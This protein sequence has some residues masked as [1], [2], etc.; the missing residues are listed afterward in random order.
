MVLKESAILMIPNPLFQ[1]CQHH[2]QSVQSLAK[3]HG[4]QVLSVIVSSGHGDIEPYGTTS[5]VMLAS[6]KG[7]MWAG[8]SNLFSFTVAINCLKIFSI[9]NWIC[10]NALKMQFSYHNMYGFYFFFL[11]SLLSIISKFKIFFNNVWWGSPRGYR[12]SAYSGF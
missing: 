8:F 11:K 10:G 7:N 9:L 6:P 4:W 3:L 1:I 12:K 5:T 2:A